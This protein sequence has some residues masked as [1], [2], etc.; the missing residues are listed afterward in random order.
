MIFFKIFVGVSDIHL[1]YNFPTLLKMEKYLHSRKPIVVDESVG[2][3]EYYD[4]D[5]M[6]KYLASRTPTIL[7]KE[8][9]GFG[10]TG[11]LIEPYQSSEVIIPPLNT[12]IRFSEFL[13]LHIPSEKESEGIS[14]T[15]PHAVIVE[16][17]DRSIA[18]KHARG[19]GYD[20]RDH[21]HPAR[22]H[23][24]LH[25]HDEVYENFSWGVPTQADTPLNRIKKSLIKKVGSQHACGSCWAFSFADTM[26][27]CLVVSGACGWSPNISTTYIM[28]CVPYGHE[29][30]AGGNPAA[31]TPYLEQTG[32]MDTSCVDYSWCSGDDQLCKSVAS[33]GHFDAKT[34]AAKLNRQIPNCGCYYGKVKKYL[35][36][37]NPGSDVMFINREVSIS[38]FRNTIRTHILDFGPVIGGYAVMANFL[39]G[40]F[41]TPSLNGGVYFDRAD[42]DGYPGSG[43]LYFNDR[44]TM[45]TRGL[46]A[47]SIVGW[48]VAKNVQY[49]N[50]KYGDVPYWHCRNSWGT[51]WGYEGGYFKIAMYPFNKIAQF[52][53]QVMTNVGGPVGSMILIRATER[54]KIVESKEIAK[55]FTDDINKT[56]SNT[57]YESP[58]EQVRLINREGILDIDLEEM[59]EQQNED[60]VEPI[61]KPPTPD[62]TSKRRIR[63]IAYVVALIAVIIFAYYYMRKNRRRR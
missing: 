51:N 38:T 55:R 36:K 40:K 22:E 5:E 16:D 25:V 39:T 4:K 27:D 33:S 21:D 8:N 31:V 60:G 49:D 11:N 58:A 63:R 20:P 56:N 42:Y 54:P 61:P 34:L 1:S 24:H 45:Q 15:N 9:V 46:H 52:D 32:V 26:S 14:Y 10:T 41:T 19:S 57:Y 44:F 28:A 37:L 47:V 2:I 3:R 17:A 53:K 6:D 18:H 43:K 48:G 30:C 50:D 29:K 59:V 13:P 7:R 23:P 12:D 62:N 35:Y